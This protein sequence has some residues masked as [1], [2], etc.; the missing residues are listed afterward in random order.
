MKMCQEGVWDGLFMDFISQKYAKA[1][2]QAHVSHDSDNEQV[3]DGIG[4]WEW[5]SWM[6]VN[7]LPHMYQLAYG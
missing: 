2:F 1:I 7:Y 4:M 5:Y 3:V 6:I